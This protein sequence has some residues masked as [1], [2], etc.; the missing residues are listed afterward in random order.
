MGNNARIIMN[1][2]VSFTINNN[3]IEGC[4]EMWNSITL[5]C[6]SHF[7]C[8]GNSIKDGK[9]AIYP[10]RGS[11]VDI[12]SNTFDENYRC[13]YMPFT[14]ANCGMGNEVF[15]L[16]PLSGNKFLCTNSLKPPYQNQKTLVGIEIYYGYVQ[17]G[18]DNYPKNE[19]N[20]IKKGIYGYLNSIV[21]SYNNE[22]ESIFDIGVNIDNSILSVISK[23]NNFSTSK[24]AIDISNTDVII[25]ENNTFNSN[26]NGILISNN[27]NKS[28]LIQDNDF[29]QVLQE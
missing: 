11:E 27:Q 23:G 28:I 19:F 20:G 24:T 15:F 8:R 17:V 4:D 25:E 16:E 13:I 26:R 21:E 1:N 14:F 3:N 2:N 5:L 10:Y 12:R 29:Q 22:F 9:N 7:V 18:D 6:G